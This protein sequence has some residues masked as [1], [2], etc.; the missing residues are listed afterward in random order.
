MNVNWVSVAIV[1]SDTVCGIRNG[2]LVVLV[3]ALQAV[4]G[5]KVPVKDVHVETMLNRVCSYPIIN[6]RFVI[7]VHYVLK[8]LYCIVPTNASRHRWIV[9]ELSEAGTVSYSVDIPRW[10]Q[11]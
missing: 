2:F 4:V 6:Y 8:T 1:G 11:A 3:V 10:C 7:I 5:F 9:A